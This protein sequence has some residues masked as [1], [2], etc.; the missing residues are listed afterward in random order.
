MP[1][2]FPFADDATA[3]VAVPELDA[4]IAKAEVKSSKTSE[5]LREA[6][7]ARLVNGSLR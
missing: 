7:R 1:K 4:A 2:P 3:A 5:K 6:T